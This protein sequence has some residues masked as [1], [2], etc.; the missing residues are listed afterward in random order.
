[1]KVIKELFLMD[2]NIN[3]T[4]TKYKNKNKIFG[5]SKCPVYF[6]LP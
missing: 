2:D 4:V 1:M 3:L 5:P 6:R